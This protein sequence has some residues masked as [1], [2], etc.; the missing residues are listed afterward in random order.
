MCSKPTKKITYAVS[1]KAGSTTGEYSISTYEG[2]DGNPVDVLFINDSKK[3]CEEYIKN[4]GLDLHDEDIIEVTRFISSY[5][6]SSQ[7]LAIRPTA[8]LSLPSWWNN[9]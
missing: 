5:H 6:I 7:D 2:I 8:G 1:T 4:H 9:E 3:V